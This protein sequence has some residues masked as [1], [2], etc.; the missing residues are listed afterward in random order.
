MEAMHAPPHRD[1]RLAQPPSSILYTYKISHAS[2]LTN[3]MPYSIISIYTEP[4]PRICR[5]VPLPVFN[6][7]PQLHEHARNKNATPRPVHV[8]EPM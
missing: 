8:R 1:L 4:T 7:R 6:V 2:S 5:S 3:Q